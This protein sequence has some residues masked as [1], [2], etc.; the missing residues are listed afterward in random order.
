MTTVGRI[1]VMS[2]GEDGQVRSLLVGHL[3]KTAKGVLHRASAGI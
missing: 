1:T 2:P 3:R